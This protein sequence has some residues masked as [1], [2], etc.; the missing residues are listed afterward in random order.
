MSS[1]PAPGATFDH[2]AHA[3][4]SIRELLPLYRDVL[5]GRF[6][7]G[8]SHPAAG[9]RAVQLGYAG[10]TK[11][12][13]IEALPGSTFLDGFLR[14]NPRGGLHHVTYRVPDLDAAVDAA[15]RAG[16]EVFGINRENPRWQEAFVHPR[17]AHGALVQFAQSVPGW[18][19]ELGPEVGLEAFLD[20]DHAGI[21]DS[22]HLS[23]KQ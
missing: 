15:R 18:P 12:E 10:D 19:P 21:L 20:D 8:A 7:F 4:S 23:P 5:G 1:P 17:C 9:Y 2:V 3:A 6:L 13:L 14:R 11:I 16:Y 22:D